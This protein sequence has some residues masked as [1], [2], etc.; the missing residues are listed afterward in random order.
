MVVIF[1]SLGIVV[2]TKSLSSNMFEYLKKL[3]SKTPEKEL[4]FEEKIKK[5]QDQREALLQEQIK[6]H[7]LEGK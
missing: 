5:L 4:T 2:L 1:P 7:E 6:L 3:F